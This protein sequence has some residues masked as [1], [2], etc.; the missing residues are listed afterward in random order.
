MTAD[1]AERIYQEAS[2]AEHKLHAD[3]YTQPVIQKRCRDK[4]W[5]A[6]IDAVEKE[7]AVKFAMQMVEGMKG[8]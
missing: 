2:L 6:V 8:D 1:E 4:G 3:K 5:E 7:C